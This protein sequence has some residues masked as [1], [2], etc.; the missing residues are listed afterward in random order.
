MRM[1]TPPLPLEKAL[2]LGR[3]LPLL[4]AILLSFTACISPDRPP[5]AAHNDLPT[6]PPTDSSESSS[7]SDADL[8][9]PLWKNALAEATLY[10]EEPHDAIV[11]HSKRE[12]SFEEMET[13]LKLLAERY[14]EQFFY[15]SFGQS[16]A[17][18]ELYVA[19]LGNPDAEKKIL[20]SAGLH[21]REYLTPLL[22]MMQIEFY[23]HYYDVGSYGEHS[24]RELLDRCCFY[25]VP[26]SNP[27]GI[28]LS[29][30]GLSSLD[31]PDLRK[32]V[33]EIYQADKEKG[34][35]S[36][37]DID[38][39]LKFWKANA[40]GVDLNR[41]FDALWEEY[42]AGERVPCHK[43]HKGPSAASEPET[44]ALVALT[45][46]LDDLAAVLCI[47]SQGEVLYWD[48]GQPAPL[49]EET[50]AFTRAIAAKNGYA[51]IEE[52]NNDASF[53][54]WCA[55]EKGL[56]AVTVETGLGTCPLYIDKL[57]A[58]WFDNFELWLLAAVYVL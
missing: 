33:E 11:D 17:G 56:I 41:N 2:P 55:L 52:Q 1:K 51:V 37:E 20:V 12:Y 36:Q 31:D 19:V 48:C 6:A 21:G 49:Y 54:D 28:M 3:L 26:M 57:E 27:D 44:R 22:T 39:Y 45:E 29:Q 23:L 50:L 4:L 32:T 58:I 38:E 7:T 10:F 5:S 34:Y 14:P 9:N 30:E 43:N 25:I 42:R 53:S 40:N 8:E 47:H 13:D 35:T 18:R 16:V 46:R 15:L 24:Y